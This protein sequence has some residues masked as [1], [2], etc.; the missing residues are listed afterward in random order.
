MDHSVAQSTVIFLHRHRGPASDPVTDNNPTQPGTSLYATTDS[1]QPTPPQVNLYDTVGCPSGG[2]HV[3]YNEQP[4]VRAVKEKRQ[5]NH[6]TSDVALEELYSKP[7]KQSKP[8]NDSEDYDYVWSAG[9]SGGDGRIGGKREEG[10]K[11]NARNQD[12]EYVDIDHSGN[13]DKRPQGIN[14]SSPGVTYTEVQRK[15]DAAT[16]QQ[17]ETPGDSDMQMVENELYN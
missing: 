1:N 12:L 11:L 17:V 3:Y 5:N 16:D 13:P 4:G 10:G 15:T 14:P 9:G 7:N 6:H 2:E 8:G